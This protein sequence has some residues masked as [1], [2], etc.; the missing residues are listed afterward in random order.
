MFLD[1]VHHEETDG[2]LYH[3][4][5][6]LSPLLS[7]PALTVGS[8]SVDCTD[9][10]K[11]ARQQSDGF[12]NEQSPYV[13]EGDPRLSSLSLDLSRRLQQCLAISEPQDIPMLDTTCSETAPA[14]DSDMI[15]LEEPLSSKLFRDALGDLSEFLVIIQS[16]GSERS[17]QSTGA[18]S[19]N[20]TI[21]NPSPRIGIVV[22][23]NLL[24][25]YLQI[26]AIYDKLFRCLR[27]Q[28]FDASEGSIAGLQTLPGLRLTGNLQ[29]KILIHAILRQFEMIERILGLPAEFRVTDKGVAYSGLFEDERARG[30][31]EAVSNSKWCHV[32]IDDH[33]GSRALSSLRD[34]IKRVQ[35][36][37]DM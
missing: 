30:L 13:L 6:D 7:P 17:G 22:I 35:V 15:S 14:A 25:A 24:S 18:G 11:E 2:P 36:Y 31:L 28:L 19:G 12:M 9:A 5:D 23:L 27:K 21:P 33:C 26:V 32:A 34:T 4:L 1:R 37:L 20:G 16:Y 8:S 29:T 3:D 10:A